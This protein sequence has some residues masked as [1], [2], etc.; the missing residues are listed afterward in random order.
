[1][2][3]KLQEMNVKKRDMI[4]RIVID[5]KNANEEMPMVTAM[6]DKDEDE[7]EKENALNGLSD[8][9]KGAGGPKPN[10]KAC[11]V[12]QE[13]KEEKM[14]EKITRIVINGKE[15]GAER[16]KPTLI[17]CQ[18][19]R[20]SDEMKK[21]DEITRIVIDDENL[22]NCLKRFKEVRNVFKGLIEKEWIEKF[23][24]LTD[25]YQGAG[26]AKRS[27]LKKDGFETFVEAV[28][29]R[30]ANGRKNG[31]LR[32]DLSRTF[33]LGVDQFP[34]SV[35][36]MMDVFRK[37][38]IDD[39][40]MKKGSDNQ[41]EFGK[42]PRNREKSFALKVS[43]RK[44]FVC[45]DKGHLLLAC[46]ERELK[47]KKEWWINTTGKSH[48]QRVSDEKNDEFSNEDDQSVRSGKSTVSRDWQ[49]FLRGENVEKVLSNDK[50]DDFFEK[51]LSD[52][53]TTTSVFA[54]PKKVTNIRDSD[55]PVYLTT[56]MGDGLLDQDATTR[57]F[58]KTVKFEFK[59]DELGLYAL[60]NES[61][62]SGNRKC[63]INSTAKN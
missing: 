53:A 35:Q 20:A 24:E 61:E 50:K 38:K 43:E 28:F 19:V 32:D 41:Q 36:A 56:N 58:G 42:G 33:A 29:M 10:L 6:K 14:I 60:A 18:V 55:N 17:G 15:N 9:E 2:Y 12:V 51:V 13:E 5:W 59:P 1:M 7:F 16:S 45:G 63:W 4:T 52:T 49:F 22:V 30:N 11:Q 34:R 3:G 27:E 46:P 47:P 8:D 62:Y 25:V 23:V 48:H 31:I 54:N 26:S 44:C 37:A 40:M 39:W 57:D 21:I